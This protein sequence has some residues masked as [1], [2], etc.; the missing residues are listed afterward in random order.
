M[1]Q[2]ASEY[3]KRQLRKFRKTKSKQRAITPVI[4]GQA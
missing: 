4:V 1:Y 3:L 2:I